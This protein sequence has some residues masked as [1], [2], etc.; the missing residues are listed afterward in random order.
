MHQ[1]LL[2]KSFNT[3]ISVCWLIIAPMG[4]AVLCFMVSAADRGA[5]T[6][7]NVELQAVKDMLAA[8]YR[9]LM[10]W[11]SG[12]SS[13]CMYYPAGAATS[14]ATRGSDEN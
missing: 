10:D 13:Y 5:S 2:I 6:T 11:F 14:V 8:N 7:R 12:E 9:L 1:M 4:M 3:K